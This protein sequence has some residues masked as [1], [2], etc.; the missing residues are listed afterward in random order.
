MAVDALKGVVA[1]LESPEWNEWEGKAV[2]H[3]T[4][5][6]AHELGVEGAVPFGYRG[7]Q[8]MPA[9]RAVIAECEEDK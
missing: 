9:V 7:P 1:A 5:T 6:R 4:R 3:E 2:Q 8:F